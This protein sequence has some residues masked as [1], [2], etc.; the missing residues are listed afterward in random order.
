MYGEKISYDCNMDKGKV[1]IKNDFTLVK[2]RWW[3]QRHFNSKVDRVAKVATCCVFHNFC[4]TWNELKPLFA[5]LG[6]R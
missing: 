3:I 4:E 6:N 5:N 2:N 1:V